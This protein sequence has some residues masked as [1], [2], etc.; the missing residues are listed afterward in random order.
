MKTGKAL[1][2]KETWIK[3]MLGAAAVMLVFALKV[4]VSEA[5]EGTVVANT[6]VIRAEAS[7][8]SEAIGS[9]ERGKTV[10]I[11]GAVKDSSGT[12]WYKVPN[13]NN[14]YGYIRSDLIETT[15]EIEITETT[16]SSS[17]AS[18][19]AASQPA[20]T[21]PTSI[22]ETAATISVQSATI[23]T[24]A[25][26]SHSAVTSLPQGTAI[27]LI[28]E[29]NDSSGMK[30]YQITC[31]YN[32]R[33]IEGYVRSDLVTVGEAVAGEGTSEEGEE[34]GETGEG[35][36]EEGEDAEQ[37]EEIS[38]SEYSDYEVVY[39]DG[40]YWLYDNI[41][42]T[43]MSV[44]NLL[45]VVTQVSENN[46]TL[47]SQVKNEKIVIIILA[48]IIVVLVIAITVLLFKLR[49]AYYYEDYE[50]EE[51]E[52]EPEPVVPRKKKKRAEEEYEEPAPVKKKRVREA[53]PAE[54]ERP[55]KKKAAPEPELKAAEKKKP[56][57]RK[58]QN[59]LVD[60]DEFEFEFL[61]MDDKDL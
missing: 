5:A 24:G 14:V 18:D 49:D 8:S 53:E 22:G 38:Q 26:T 41:N 12:V 50:E 39:S 36:G 32:G 4:F 58:P 16:A 59:F 57:P 48:V 7:T 28:G 25:S 6:A 9:T 47:Q 13:G 10:D 55:V 27:T 61:N 3:G 42:V 17:T 51:I 2:Q 20:D 33:T 31:T 19:T 11:V 40:T 1:F 15:D 21:V 56:A 43:R 54:P 46:T 35:S 37:S 60:D 45:E 34:G 44:T 23:R 52:E 30:W 29:A